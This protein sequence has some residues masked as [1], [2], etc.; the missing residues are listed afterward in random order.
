MCG[1]AL[2]AGSKADEAPGETRRSGRVRQRT[3]STSN[4]ELN[5]TV[6]KIRED[7]GIDV[8]GA[9]TGAAGGVEPVESDDPL[10]A[11]IEEIESGDN[12]AGAMGKNGSS[13]HG[14]APLAPPPSFAP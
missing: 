10:S 6:H 14:P 13:M 8:S 2:D 1:A 4:D 3:M 7:M 12:A 5:S 9:D 11:Y